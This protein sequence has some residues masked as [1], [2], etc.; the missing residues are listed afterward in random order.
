MCLGVLRAWNLRDYYVTRRDKQA[1]GHTK[2]VSSGKEFGFF[3][4]ASSQTSYFPYPSSSFSFWKISSPR[5]KKAKM[6][7]IS[8]KWP[9]KCK[10]NKDNQCCN[11]NTTLSPTPSKE[12]YLEGLNVSCP[13][14]EKFLLILRSH[15]VLMVIESYKQSWFTN[16]Y[17]IQNI[18]ENSKNDLKAVLHHF[19]R[20]EVSSGERGHGL[21]FLLFP[22]P[23]YVGQRTQGSGQREEQEMEGRR[24]RVGPFGGSFAFSMSG[25]CLKLVLY[26][27][28][29]SGIL[30][31]PLNEP[32]ALDPFELIR[33]FSLL[34]G[35]S[36][37]L[38]PPPPCS[39]YS[40]SFTVCW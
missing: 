22:K 37:F 35:H 30:R 2:P 33:C 39:R 17:P 19:P 34:C 6:N 23:Q 8:L 27:V 29:L 16:Q 25:R 32:S 38:L 31:G 13:K 21:G 4:I 24:N 20:L 14:I 40:A 11:Q 7:F 36:C 18:N 3:L 12:L 28:G 1:Q 5:G 15:V 9:D 10:S 26:H